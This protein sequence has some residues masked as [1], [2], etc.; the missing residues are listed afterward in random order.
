MGGLC[1]DL[2]SARECST[3]SFGFTRSSNIRHSHQ[4][5]KLF[6]L[7][8]MLP[9]NLD[10]PP[11]KLIHFLSRPNLF[12][13]FNCF[14]RFLAFCVA[15][16]QLPLPTSRV[17]LAVFKHRWSTVKDVT[18]FYPIIDD[19]EGSVEHSHQ[20]TSLAYRARRRVPGC[21]SGFRHELLTILL[22][23][24]NHELIYAH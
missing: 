17:N 4:S 20:V 24:C 13:F 19:A 15:F 8:I 18:W 3:L 9:C 5:K 12:S 6:T 7:L 16:S 2:P 11:T 10:R 22:S 21:L 14:R 23:Y 1:C